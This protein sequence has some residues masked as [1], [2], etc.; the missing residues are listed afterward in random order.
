MKLFF[1]YFFQFVIYFLLVWQQKWQNDNNSLHIG[2]KMDLLGFPLEFFL[3]H[4][5]LY[6]HHVFIQLTT[7][8]GFQLLL[9][10]HVGA[11]LQCSQ[12]HRVGSRY[13]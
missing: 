8:I 9:F 2:F 10:V 11:I 7:P 1:I 3:L 5:E 13:T 4:T 6:F 12:I